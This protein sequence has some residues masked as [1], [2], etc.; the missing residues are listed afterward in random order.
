MLLEATLRRGTLGLVD[1]VRLARSRPPTTCSSSSISSR[2]CSGSAASATAELARRGGGVRQAAARSGQPA[3]DL[4]I[5]VVL[6]M[7][8]DFIGD[9]MEYPGLPEA[10]NDRPVPR[11]A[12]DARRAALGHHGPGAR[13]PVRT[14]R[15]AARAAAAERRRRRSGSAPA[16]AARA[17]AHLGSLGAAPAAWDADRSR[18]LRGGRHARRRAVDRTPRKPTRTPARSEGRRNAERIFK[19]LTDT[20]SDPRGVRRPTSVAELA[21]ICEA[22]EGEVIG[23]SSRSSAAPGARS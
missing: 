16:G 20:F 11:P 9:C 3:E 7:R 10:V 2:S 23:R 4:P 5:Y 21:A 6:T 15:A 14:H 17:D 8:S 19:A 12:D 13:S 1:A 18:E 22:P